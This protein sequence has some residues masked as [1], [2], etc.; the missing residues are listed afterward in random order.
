MSEGSSTVTAGAFTTRRGRFA[1]F[2]EQSGGSLV[3][4][5][6]VADVGR[7]S[8]PRAFLPSSSFSTRLPRLPL[9]TGRVRN[10]GEPITTAS[11]RFG[12]SFTRASG[13]PMRSTIS[14]TW[15]ASSGGLDS[16][17]STKP[18]ARNCRMAHSCFTA[19]SRVSFSVRDFCCGHLPVSH[20]ATSAYG[21]TGDSDHSALAGGRSPP[22]AVSSCP[23][24]SPDC[25][26]RVSRHEVD[27]VDHPRSLAACDAD[28]HALVQPVE[29][30]G[31]GPVCPL[32]RSVY[33]LGSTSSP[34]PRR[35]STSALP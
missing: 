9:A 26:A 24:S 18:P 17:A 23:I 35:A 33:P 6:F 13:A 19:V 11:L 1:G 30:G 31:S 32:V 12:Q 20:A 8:W 15:S 7:R 2:T 10:V 34:R 16:A 21:R 4:W 5:S 27:L 22:W 25:V 29:F 14:F 28:E 3:A